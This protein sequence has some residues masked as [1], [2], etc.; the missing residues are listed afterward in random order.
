MTS[1]KHPLIHTNPSGSLR[2]RRRRVAGA[3]LTVALLGAACGS[4]DGDDAGASQPA[5]AI[6][7]TDADAETDEPA[8]D[9]AP[10]T[11]A[12]A[13]TE[14]VDTM[15]PAE[16]PPAEEPADEEPAD[17]AMEEDDAAESAP[18]DELRIHHPETLAFAAPFTVLDPAGQLGG[19][20][21]EVSIETWTTPD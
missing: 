6:D 2:R 19:V 21:T 3:L 20:A 12:P 11:D 17:D 13:A 4:D 1:L 7:T 9:T 16:E 15:P 18:L 10:T 5:D 8:P 14:P